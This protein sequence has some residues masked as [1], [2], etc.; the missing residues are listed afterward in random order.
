MDSSLDPKDKDIIDISKDYKLE[1]RIIKDSTFLPTSPESM[2]LQDKIAVYNDGVGWKVIPLDILMRY[3]VIHDKHFDRVKNKK[4][5]NVVSDISVTFCP[6]TFSTVIYFGK[7]APT[8]KV[9]KGNIVIKDLDKDK[10][11]P[12]MIGSK[13]VRKKEVRLMTLRNVVSNY[14]DCTYLDIKNL[15]M[16]NIVKEEYLAN[17]EIIYPFDNVSDKFHPK[18]LVYGIEYKSKD[19]KVEDYKYSVVVGSDGSVEEANSF[20]YVKNGYDVYFDSVIDKIR[21]KGGV[22]IPCFWFGWVGMHPDVRVIKL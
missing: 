7:Y 22:V 13:F 1:D 6:F 4:G 14:P 20:D 3:V 18:T 2:S 19:V 9:Y 15:D 21:D 12:Q 17:K 8:N 11:V 16:P 10:L 5:E